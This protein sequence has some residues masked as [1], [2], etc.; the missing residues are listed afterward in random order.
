MSQLPPKQVKGL[1][2]ALEELEELKKKVENLEKE[3]SDLKKDLPDSKKVKEVL[4]YIEKK[5]KGG[6][7]NF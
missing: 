4:E 6:D 1:V 7:P 2:E 5:K 3:L